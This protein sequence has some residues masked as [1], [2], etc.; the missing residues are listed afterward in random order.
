MEFHSGKVPQFDLPSKQAID[1]L[2]GDIVLLETLL[3]GSGDDQFLRR[4]F[5]RS[6]FALI[7]AH[8]SFLKEMTHNLAVQMIVP[9]QEHLGSTRFKCPVHLINQR[10]TSSEIALL[11]D[12]GVQIKENGEIESSR[13]LV[14]FKRHLKFCLRS[15]C[16]IFGVEF[17][18]DFKRD[19]GWTAL[20]QSIDVR[21]RITHPKPSESQNISDREVSSVR[22]AYLWMAQANALFLEESSK[23]IVNAFLDLV[24]WVKDYAPDYIQLVNRDLEFLRALANIPPLPREEK[25][26]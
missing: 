10:I 3:E 25:A 17:L 4:C 8:I 24:S 13:A 19:L 12:E 15:S 11:R 5:V 6:A 22:L 23:R 26:S 2:T 21:H 9:L 20:M 1:A 16:R 18:W 14:D 7:E